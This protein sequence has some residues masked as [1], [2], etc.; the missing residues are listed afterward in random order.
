[1]TEEAGS[2]KSDLIELTADIVAAFV[3]NSPVPVADLPGLISSVNAALSRLVGPAV[4]EQ[5]V[6]V[7]PAVNP[8]KSVTPDFV[9]CP[10]DGKTF[11]IPEAASRHPTMR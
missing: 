1:M 7:A 10:E 3:Q 9:I 5:P 4:A 6:Q 2:T 8:K 11:Q